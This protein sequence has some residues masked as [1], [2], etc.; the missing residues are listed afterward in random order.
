MTAMVETPTGPRRA[1]VAFIFV[2][3]MLDMLALGMIIPVLP[4]LIVDFVGGDAGRAATIFGLFGTVWAL[5]QFVCSPVLG[6]LS[7][8]FG[9]RPVVLLSNFGLGLDYIVMALAPDLGWLLVGRII[10]GMTAA[11]VTTSFAYIADVTPP[12]K[13]A[14]AFG[15]M[16]AAFGVGFVLGPAM[17][18]LLGEYG[19]RLP[20]WVAAGLSLLNGAY[21]LFVLPESLVHENRARF[22]W[23]RANPIGSLRL[24][25]GRPQLFGLATLHFLGQLAHVVL[26]SSFALYGIYRYG[27]DA[28]AIGITLA[29]VGVSS[30]IVQAGLVG[31][32]V[33]R[34][35]ERRALLTGLVFG[36]A[37]FAMFGLAPTSWWFWAGIPVLALWGFAN[38]AVQSLMT[39]RVAPTEQGRLQGAASSLTGIANMVGPFLF[40]TTFSFFIAA[41]NAHVPGAPFLLAAL[42]LAGGIA[43]ALRTAR[44]SPRVEPA[45]APLP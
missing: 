19:P 30:M 43:L 36:V 37:G 16:G 7:D 29:V 31:R 2:T 35:G 25:L 33:K 8:R 42:L 13:R 18:G 10:S 4:R 9:R 38:P 40:T 26:P 17:G 44:P 32:V 23:K 22:T 14:G 12:E 1:A 34:F 5:M 24:L 11:S 15:M 27:W 39:S 28:R 21:G 3:V 45:P 41:G 6:A 20:F